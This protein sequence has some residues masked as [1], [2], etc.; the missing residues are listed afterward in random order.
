MLKGEKRYRV[1]FFC[2]VTLII[3]FIWIG[4][5]NAWA[6]MPANKKIVVIDAGHGEWDPGMFHSKIKEKDINLVITE[7]LQLLMELGGAVVLTT[8]SDDTAL[9][10]KKRADLSARANIANAAGADIYLSIHQNSFASADVSG[11]QVFYHASSESSK[12]LAEFIQDR[13][14][15]FIGDHQGKPRTRPAK[16]S[17]TYYVLKKTNMPAVIVE[18]GFMSNYRDLKL[19]QEDNFQDKIAWAVYMGVMDYFMHIEK[20]NPPK[21]IDG[22]KE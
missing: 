8:R 21:P 1:A 14:N 17:E 15:N 5:V 18:C 13:L 6:S 2:V 9:A 16:A 4:P 20:P 10:D 12:V 11:A 22:I 7:K 19:L 3:I